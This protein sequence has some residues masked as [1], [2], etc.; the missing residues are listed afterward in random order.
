MREKYWLPFADHLHMPLS[1]TDRLTVAE[2]DQA[3][4]YVEKKWGGQR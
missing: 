3:V 4:A 1:E 2:F